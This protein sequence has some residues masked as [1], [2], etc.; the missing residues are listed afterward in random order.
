MKITYSQIEPQFRESIEGEVAHHAAKLN[1]LLKHYAPDLVQLHGSLEKTPRKT[2][3]EFALHLALP[4]GQLH[5]TGSG[6]D[7]R[8]SAKAAFAEIEAQVKKHQQKVRKDY[9]WKRK[10]GRGLLK[11]GEAPSIG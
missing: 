5:A 7:V 2:G 3:F 8:A 1:R 11:P 10:R 9:V 6:A 4:T